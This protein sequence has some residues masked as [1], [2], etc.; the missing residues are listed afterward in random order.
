MGFIEKVYQIERHIHNVEHWFGAAAVPG[1]NHFGDLDT[2]T[3]YQSTAG[4][5]VYGAWLQLLGSADTPVLLDMAGFDLRRLLFVDV[6]VVANQKVHKVEIGT[7]DA[8]SQITISEFEFVPLRGGIGLPIELTSSLIPV[9][10]KVWLRHWCDGQNATT[11]DFKIGIHE[12][13]AYVDELQ[14][15]ADLIAA[16][17]LINAHLDNM[18]TDID[19]IDNNVNLLRRTCGWVKNYLQ[20]HSKILARRT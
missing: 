7:G 18:N 3:N 6:S 20:G 11:M 1:V 13:P 5:N 16:V 19:N 9:N 17:A 12:H 4:N 8:G 2:M 15:D 10:S 14:Q